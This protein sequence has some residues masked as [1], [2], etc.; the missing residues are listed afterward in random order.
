MLGVHFNS[1]TLGHYLEIEAALPWADYSPWDYM[2]V[3]KIGVSVHGEQP[4][5]QVPGCARAFVNLENYML[6]RKL[7]QR[8]RY[9]SLFY[10]LLPVR[11]FSQ[12]AMEYI[13]RY[14]L[15]LLCHKGTCP[16]CDSR[17]QYYS[18]LRTEKREND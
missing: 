6:R 4:L 7:V 17:R 14:P 9:G 16:A 2:G 10:Y 3:E 11:S 1:L 13:R 5:L 18:H 12:R 8:R 15:R